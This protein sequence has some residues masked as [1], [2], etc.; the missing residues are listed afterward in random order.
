MTKRKEPPK[1]PSQLADEHWDYLEHILL[2]EM[3]MKMLLYKIAFVHGYEHGKDGED[4][5]R[6]KPPKE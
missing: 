1:S 2:E 6:T 3:R 4:G 5:V